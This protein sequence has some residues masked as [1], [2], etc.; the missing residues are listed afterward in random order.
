MSALSCLSVNPVK[1]VS[2]KFQMSPDCYI[3]I[4][5]HYCLLSK[6]M[7]NDILCIK[8]IVTFKQNAMILN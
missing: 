3:F 8:V 7:Y 6:Y 5:F 2:Y 4:T 1:N